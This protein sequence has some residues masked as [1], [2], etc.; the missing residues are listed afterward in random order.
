MRRSE[1]ARQV[2]R[3]CLINA[4]Q[5]LRS[6][7]V[8]EN[9][10]LLKYR[11]LLFEELASR[12]NDRFHLLTGGA[13]TAVPRQKTLEA[14]LDWSYRLLGEKQPSQEFA[15]PEQLGALAVFLCSEA[16]AQIRG[17]ARKFP[18]PIREH[19]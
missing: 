10:E 5:S 11:A 7:N 3:F 19:D 2:F 1:R 6:T 4:E 17:A 16:A 8:Q 12:L 15:T 14:S 18:S 9:T 13:R